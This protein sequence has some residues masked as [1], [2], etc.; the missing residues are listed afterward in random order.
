MDMGM[1]MDMDTLICAIIR[2]KIPS[3][4]LGDSASKLY[5][6]VLLWITA[7]NVA[8]GDTQSV[9]GRARRVAT[10]GEECSCTSRNGREC[11]QERA[12]ARLIGDMAAMGNPTRQRHI[13]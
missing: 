1:G 4:A 3:H 7:K 9:Q 6:R 10:I 8:V 2:A 12:W 11:E 13:L 5:N